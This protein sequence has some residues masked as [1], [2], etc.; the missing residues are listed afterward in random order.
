MAKV[1]AP[2]WSG[3]VAKW[4][5]STGPTPAQAHRIRRI[6]DGSMAVTDCGLT[7][8]AATNLEVASEVTCARCLAVAAR[9]GTVPP[10]GIVGRIIAD[11]TPRS[12]GHRVVSV[13]GPAGGTSWWVKTACGKTRRLSLMLEREAV[14]CGRCLAAET[15]EEVRDA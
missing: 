7:T 8:D 13:A 15:T 12:V 11:P 9:K 1:L 4:K 5:R 2:F 3:K 10:P 6:V 14:T